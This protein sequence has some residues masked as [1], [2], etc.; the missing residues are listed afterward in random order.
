MSDDKVFATE[1]W[2]CA[3]VR[4]AKGKRAV[5]W[6]MPNGYP[7]QY[8]DKSSYATGAGYDV[9]VCREDG[10]IW[11]RGKPAYAG[12]GGAASEVRARWL[13]LEKQA[14]QELARL[15]RERKEKGR[16]ALD[17]AMEP[18]IAYAAQ[19]RTRTQRAALIADVIE[20]ITMSA[21]R[22]R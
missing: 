15:A 1:R 22:T 8:D 20:H 13:V 19:C 10:H 9:L 6:M 16:D 7:V 11:R 4:E 2:I 14:E 5:E 17:E 21:W 3:G 12:S 18:L